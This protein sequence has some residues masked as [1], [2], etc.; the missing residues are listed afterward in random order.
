[1]PYFIVIISLN[2]HHLLIDTTGIIPKMLII[3][4]TFGFEL[5]HSN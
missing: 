1:M 4:F 2:L 3:V 5:F